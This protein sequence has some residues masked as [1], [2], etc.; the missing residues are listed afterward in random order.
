[1]VADEQILNKLILINFINKL[2]QHGMPPHR[3]AV[4]RWRPFT[5]HEDNFN[6]LLLHFNH[7]CIWTSQ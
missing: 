5:N 3:K 7:F 6:Q 2:A 4:K 1:M